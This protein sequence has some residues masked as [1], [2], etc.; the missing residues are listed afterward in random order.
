MKAEIAMQRII[1]TTLALSASIG[2]LAAGGAYAA[3]G[4]GM[5]GGMGGM[6]MPPSDS[7][8]PTTAGDSV[9]GLKEG[10]TV[11]DSAGVTV[12]RITKVGQSGGSAAALVDVDGKTVVVMGSTL[13][14][15]GDT[16]T[17]TQ[18]KDEIKA[19]PQP[20]PG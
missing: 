7:R 11:K 12:G 18:T 2:L 15:S 10:M 1:S 17:S 6:S 14:V 13:S 16:A 4:G 8:L 9:S 19:S 3:P 5:G 20:R